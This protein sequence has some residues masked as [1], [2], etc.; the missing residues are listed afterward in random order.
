MI[1]EHDLLSSLTSAQREAVTHIEG[2]MLVLAGPGS[3]K[4][5]V[6]TYRI[7]YLITQGVNPANILA[8]TFT[9]KAATEMRG[10]LHSLQLPRGSTLCTF[11]SLAARLLREFSDLA[12]LPVDFSIYDMADQKAAMGEALKLCE[13]DS[14]NFPPARMLDRISGCKNRIQTPEEVTTD[15]Y[16]FPAKV[17]GRIYRAYQ[18]ILAA[19]AAVDFDDL[20]MKLALLLRDQQQ[21]RDQLNDR[22]HYLLV[23]EY[24]D[25]NHCQYQIAR[26][27][28]LSHSNLFVTGDP[29]QSIYGWRGADIGNILAFEEDYPQTRVVRLEENFRST[30]EVLDLAD[31]VIVSNQYRRKKQLFTSKP[32]GCACELI[33]CRNEYEEAQAMA[34]W[35]GRLRDE[36]LEYRDMAV[37]YRVNSMSRVLEG[38]LRNAGIPYQIVRGLEFFQRREIKNMLAYLKLLVNPSD[39]VALKRIINQPVRGI[40]PTTVNRLFDYSQSTGMNIWQ[41]LAGVDQIGSLGSAA[42][43]KVKKFTEIIT[44]L[45]AH[46]AGPVTRIM[47]LTYEQSGLADAHIATET[48]DAKNNVNELINSAVMYDSES[49]APS[50]ADY[51]QQIALMSDSDSYDEQSGAVSLMTLHTAK[52]LEFPAVLIV[53]LED[54]L[55]PHIRSTSSP[56]IVNRNKEIEE[57]RRL[58]FVGMTRAKDRLTLSYA[59]DRTVQGSVKAAIVSRFLRN[60]LGLVPRSFES[61][62]FAGTSGDDYE[63]DEPVYDEVVDQTTDFADGQLVR[64]PS[65]GVG[66]IE[67]ILPSSTNARAVILFGGCTRKTLV[68]KYAKLE[69]IDPA[70]Y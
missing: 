44:G 25:T 23:D 19:N 20:L 30:P 66:R 55:I 61:G 15:N 16:G 67:R 45:K 48:D 62:E 6:I 41:V 8:I 35:A 21:V 47:K 52:G 12:G 26:G 11:H 40:G 24:Q 37:F 5:R 56:D 2:P 49:D 29:D 43:A 38:A 36:G 27:L 31:Q 70:D 51:L 4:T 59:H 58:L 28:T 68:L 10:R 60:L 18:D 63:Y 50:L 34:Q 14:Q 33:A 53:G 39:Q 32:S 65:L 7:A 17:T 54:G 46:S 1:L 57:E 22:Y 64:H 9:N 42:K 69:R 13:L 3:G